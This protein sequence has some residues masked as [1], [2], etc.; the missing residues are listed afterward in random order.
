M[1][2]GRITVGPS[3]SGYTARSYSSRSRELIQE[4]VFKY[5]GMFFLRYSAHPALFTLS[6]RMVSSRSL[7]SSAIETLRWR[8]S[9]FSSAMHREFATASSCGEK[10][11]RGVKHCITALLM[12]SHNLASR[13]Y[14]VL[15]RLKLAGLMT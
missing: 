12:M 2:C 6:S 7:T 9:F 8:I 1:T 4:M 13:A 15:L 3:V 10:D 5:T 14:F 11:A